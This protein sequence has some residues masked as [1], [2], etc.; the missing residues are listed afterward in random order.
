[1]KA[2]RMHRNGGPEV[3]VWEDCEIAPPGPGQVQIRHTAVA[4]NFSDVNVR[5]GGF[6]IARPLQFPVILGN[7]GAGVVAAV[8]EG[9]VGFKPGQRVGYVGSGGPFYEDTG[10]YAEVRNLP[11]KCLIALPEM[12]S[13][14]QAAAVMLKGLTASMV[15]N[16]YFRPKAGDVILNHGAASGVGLILTQWCR[17]LGATV[18]G[19]VGSEEKAEI[20][21][22][23]GCAHPVLYRDVDFVGEVKK[24]APEGVDSVFDGVGKDTCLKSLDCMRPFSMLVNY[25]NSS[26][27]PEPV[28][29]LLLAKKGSLAISRPAFS[30]HIAKEDDKRGAFDELFSLVHAGVIK[31][32]VGRSYRLQDAADAHRD[33]EARRTVGSVVLD[34]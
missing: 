20:V 2:I 21:R 6:Y 22:R 23:H 13:D 16:R 26:G 9:V 17:H 19:T 12:I 30:F 8:G 31:V 7:E 1:M 33:L 24:I 15:I 25:G 27:H 14:R 28:D 11:A 4:L 34:V 29:L 10:S 3:L 18:I 32:D 5:R